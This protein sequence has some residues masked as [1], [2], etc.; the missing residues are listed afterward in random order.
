MALVLNGC[1]FGYEWKDFPGYNLS[2]SGGSIARSFRTTMEWIVSNRHLSIDYVFI[3]L[4]MVSRFEIARVLEQNIPIE[5]PYILGEAYNH[6]HIMA[7]LSDTCYMSWDYAFMKII[8]FS[9]WLEQQGIKYLIW[10]QCNMFNRNDIKGW[11]G[12]E[13]LKLIDDNPR[14]IPLF[15]FCGNQYMYDNGGKWEE[16]DSHLE[17]NIRHYQ[18]ES[19][20]ILQQYLEKYMKDVLNEKVEWK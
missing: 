9:A 14:I 17:T 11:R 2:Q 16:D 18:N 20:I 12:M 19:Y 4:T 10:D 1:S 13:K 8:T 5:G 3:P 7:E 6:Y 15:D